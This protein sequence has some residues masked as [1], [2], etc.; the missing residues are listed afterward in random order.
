MHRGRYIPDGGALSLSQTRDR[1]GV[2]KG[3]ADGV[4]AG[5][6]PPV[7]AICGPSMVKPAEGVVLSPCSFPRL[8]AT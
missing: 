7:K 8:L 6:S 1:F 2:S 4:R 3:A 5:P